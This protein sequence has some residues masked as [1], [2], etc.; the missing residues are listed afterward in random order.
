LNKFIAYLLDPIRS[1][2]WVQ[3]M[4]QV[5]MLLGGILIA[6]SH[7]S[8]DQVGALEWLIFI[9]YGL[10]FFWMAALLQLYLS[11]SGV[12]LPESS[13]EM[14]RSI[15]QFIIYMG[16]IV[17][18][19]FSF[20]GIVLG[21]R[22]GLT[23]QHYAFYGIWMGG[24]L[25]GM[26]LP[27]WYYAKQN[28][29]K[30]YQVSVILTLVYLAIFYAA[31]LFNLSFGTLLFALASFGSL[32]W[33]Y[34][35][36]KLRESRSLE[37]LFSRAAI[38]LKKGFPLAVYTFLGGAAIIIDTLLVHYFYGDGEI[39]AIFKYGSRELPITLVLSAALSN[40]LLPFISKE[41]NKID[42]LELLKNRSG[43]L[44]HYLFAISI[45]LLIFSENLYHFLYGSRFI[46]A[47]I[48]FDCMLF[49]VVARAVFPQ[50]V[51]IALHQSNIMQT[52]GWIEFTLN[53]VLSIIFVYWIG[54]VGIV[55]A[56]II[57]Y[58]FEKIYLAFILKK[59][60]KLELNQYM[61]PLPFMAWSTVLVFIFIFKYI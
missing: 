44:M 37:R 52:V 16:P 27:Y 30:M 18:V 45:I 51:I 28:I 38:V 22:Y 57:A 10:T 15:G 54:I 39:M 61:H 56:T 25:G 13:R 55:L 12:N 41:G 42:G 43:Q 36:F 58:T 7:L 47:V 48:L 33:V 23:L 49:V 9:G 40:A 1:F 31:Y 14:G 3:A 32:I 46:E 60:F 35:F 20:L 34:V 19:L 59:Q 5:G 26:F 50:T 21:N 8:L 6:R 29:I 11:Y 53:T 4:R 17:V 2:Q 24:S